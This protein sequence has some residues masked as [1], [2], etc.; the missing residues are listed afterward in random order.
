MSAS[1]CLRQVNLEFP[2][3]SSPH[4]FEFSVAENSAH[5][6]SPEFSAADNSKK[7]MST[8]FSDAENSTPFFLTKFSERTTRPNDHQPSFPQDSG[9]LDI[10]CILFVSSSFPQSFDS[11]GELDHKGPQ[12]NTKSRN[13]KSR[14]TPS[15]VSNVP[16]IGMI[17]GLL[18]LN[19]FI[20][21]VIYSLW[22]QRNSVSA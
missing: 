2:A 18:K 5:L 9:E 10:T 6:L 1:I 11:S 13:T 17:K 7:I 16:I 20:L 15:R 19:L 14:G 12:R 8:E 21:K 3:S 4:I 22:S